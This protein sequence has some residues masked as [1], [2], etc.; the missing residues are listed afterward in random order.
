MT[1]SHMNR[2]SRIVYARRVSAPPDEEASPRTAAEGAVA[3]TRRRAASVERAPALVEE[4]LLIPLELDP[5]LEPALDV[6]VERDPLRLCPD[7]P[8][9]LGP[10]PCEWPPADE[11]ELELAFRAVGAPTS[12]DLEPDGT[13]ARTVI[14]LLPLLLDVALASVD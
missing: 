1:R 14:V 6:D 5:G 3:A 2:D 12:R 8:L 9:R 11:T 10:W 4:M 7:V 13:R